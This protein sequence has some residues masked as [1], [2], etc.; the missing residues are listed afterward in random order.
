MF[1]GPDLIVVTHC[2]QGFLITPAQCKRKG[3]VGKAPLAGT[4][5]PGLL[6]LK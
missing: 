3:E 6:V 1:L 2:E 4:W 5:M